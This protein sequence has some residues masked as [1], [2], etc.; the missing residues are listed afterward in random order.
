MV[1][2]VMLSIALLSAI[3][4][5]RPVIAA[6]AAS[7]EAEL[8][9]PVQKWI[10]A[11]NKGDIPAAKAGCADA[12]SVI[13]E[14]PPFE[15]YGAGACMKWMDDFDADAKTKG[16]TD[17]VVSV[18]KPLHANA[19][20]DRGYLVLPASY[21]YKQNGKPAEQTGATLTVAMQKGAAGWTMS[22]WAWSTGK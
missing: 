10:D 11:F 19:T 17:A 12:M 9:P 6:D 1:R 5:A 4:A 20:G 14:F 15:W 22:G 21:T 18:G 3:V 7:A 16:V 13:D 2:K 8:V